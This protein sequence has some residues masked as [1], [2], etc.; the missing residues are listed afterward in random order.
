MAHKENVLVF[1]E[2]VTLEAGKP[3]TVQVNSEWVQLFSLPPIA[4]GMYLLT[5]KPVVKPEVVVGM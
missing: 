2:W 3:Q 4:V 5:K 1:Q